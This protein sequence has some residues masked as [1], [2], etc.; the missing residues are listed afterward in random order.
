MIAVNG[1]ITIPSLVIKN[2]L[3]FETAVV[4]DSSASTMTIPE[5]KF[6]FIRRVLCLESALIKI[7]NSSPFV[8]LAEYAVNKSYARISGL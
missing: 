1:S 2:P 7:R 3:G 6:S 8:E 5:L 4:P